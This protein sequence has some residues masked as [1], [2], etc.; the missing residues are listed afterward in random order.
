LLKPC[1]V[2]I[3]EHFEKSNKNGVHSF[4][5][6]FPSQAKEEQASQALPVTTEAS[7]LCVEEGTLWH[8]PFLS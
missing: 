8:F 1:C 4:S 2:E 3:G 7:W 5:F 6:G